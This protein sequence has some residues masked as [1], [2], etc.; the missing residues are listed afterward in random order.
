MIRV[1]NLTKHYETLTA[2]RSVSLEVK[3]GEILA[4]IGTSGSGKTT[5]LKMLNGLIPRSSGNIFI[6]EIPI[7]KQPLVELRRGMGYVIQDVGLFPHYNVSRNIGVMSEI[8]GKKMSPNEIGSLLDI[9]GVPRE[10]LQFYPDQLSGGQQQRVG[11]ARAL[12]NDP[13][14]LLMDEPF[15]ALDSIT[16]REIQQEFIHLPWIHSKAVVIVTHDLD[17]AALLGDTVCLMDQGEI[18]QIGS[19]RSLVFSP[20]NDFVDHFISGNRQQLEWRAIKIIDLLPFLTDEGEGQEISPLK[21]IADV[22]ESGFCGVAAFQGK[23]WRIDP[24]RLLQKY[25]THRSEITGGIT[26]G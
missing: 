18:Q 2:V 10:Y 4:L 9:V 8:Q 22:L 13:D 21:T 5:L 15:G 16:R 14:I 7:D 19:L 26:H 3:K 20:A 11:I 25:Y 24:D 17:E 23:N 12:A 1:Q 6:R